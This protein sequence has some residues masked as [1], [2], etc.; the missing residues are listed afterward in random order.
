[1]KCH[2][3]GAMEVIPRWHVGKICKCIVGTCKGRVSNEAKSY[4]DPVEDRRERLFL[5]VEDL[6]FFFFDGLGDCLLLFPPLSLPVS[7]SGPW[8]LGLLVR[9]LLAGVV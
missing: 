3:G 1:M 7:L 8:A 4:F 6:L 2:V 5:V 9:V